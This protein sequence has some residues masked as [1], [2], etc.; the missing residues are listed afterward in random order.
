MVQ[1]GPVELAIIILIIVIILR[2]RTLTDM[3]KN[4]GNLVREYRRASRGEDV[5]IYKVASI[6]GIDTSGK[7]LATISEEIREKLKSTQ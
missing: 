6:L 5:E 3:A 4:L 2:P 1:L 7:D